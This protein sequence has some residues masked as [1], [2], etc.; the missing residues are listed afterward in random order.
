MTNHTLLSDPQ[1][2]IGQQ[3]N[4]DS[5]P[6]R[7]RL[8]GL[9]RDALGFISAT[10]QRYRF[11]DFRKKP[12]P[13]TSLGSPPGGL[14]SLEERLSGT[15]A[16]LSKLRDEA[17]SSV[18]REQVQVILDALR[19]ISSTAQCAALGD[20]LEHVEAGAL[21]YV[22][23]VAAF[24]TMEEARAWLEKQPHPPVSA[25]VLIDN[26]Y[27]DVVHDLVTDV[28]RLPRNRDLEYYLAE[29]KREELPDSSAAFSKR[30]EADA[31]WRAQPRSV[32]WA[33]VSIAGEPYVAA[34]Y[35]NIDHR[36]LY[37]LSMAEGYRA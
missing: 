7:A 33:W 21:P 5:S 11:E 20:Y 19:F 14:A 37:P 16:F 18:E 32:R 3:W 28:R 17:R 31:W 15:S 2:W 24:S 26:A 8:L 36:A 10:G 13:P 35:P 22:V 6:E 34:Y 30:A 1:E 23:V 12:G 27:H 29:L 9:A 25:N 4:R